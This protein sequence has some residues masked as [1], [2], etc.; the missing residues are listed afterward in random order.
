MK[1]T[2]ILIPAIT[3]I[4]KFCNGSRSGRV[5]SYDGEGLLF[6]LYLNYYIL[7]NEITN[8]KWQVLQ[9][10]LFLQFIWTFSWNR[11]ELQSTILSAWLYVTFFICNYVYFYSIVRSILV[12]K[13][14]S[15]GCTKMYKELKKCRWISKTSNTPPWPNFV[16]PRPIEK[17]RTSQW[18]SENH[19]RCFRG[20]PRFLL[21]PFII[22][23]LISLN[24]IYI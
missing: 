18:N 19:I 10:N 6:A 12:I 15:A 14:S 4:S 16:L 23:S 7:W 21:W 13:L 22:N 17:D 3:N 20:H 1:E 24:D 5:P 8:S 2:R 11:R 9:Y